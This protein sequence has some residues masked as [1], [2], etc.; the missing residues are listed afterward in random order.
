MNKKAASYV[1]WAIS[2]AIFLTY[3]LTIFLFIKPGYT[4]LYT[5]EILSIVKENFEKDTYWTIKKIPLFVEKCKLTN[6]EQE[7]IIINVKIKQ[8][9]YELTS[10]NLPLKFKPG[11]PT[12]KQLYYL[13]YSPN[14]NNNLELELET[15]HGT[16]NAELGL[17]KEITG[18]S[19][20]KL[21]N[22]PSYKELKEKWN[23]PR[24][25]SISINNKQ[26]TNNPEPP[27][28]INIFVKEYNE[29]I[30]NPDGT[31]KKITLNIKTW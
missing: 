21:N 20:K 6:P 19:Q 3:I 26:I 29:K 22:L 28:N 25:F 2:I 27:Q 14:K 10:K 11:T 18:I 17:I 9:D 31:Y 4:P 24:D 23:F 12:T 1:D 8:G 13:T 15:Q 30:L 16:C 7:F 5:K